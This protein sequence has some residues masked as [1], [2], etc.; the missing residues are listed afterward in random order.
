MD[1]DTSEPDGTLE[2]EGAV[3]SRVERENSDTEISHRLMDDGNRMRKRRLEMSPRDDG[4]K[5][6]RDV[7]EVILKPN[8]SSAFELGCSIM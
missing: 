2:E 7:L 8:S 6:P 5:K 4:Q 3:E 1:V